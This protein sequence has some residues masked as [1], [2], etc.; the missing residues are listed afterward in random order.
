MRPLHPARVRTRSQGGASLSY[1]EAYDVKAMLIRVFGFGGFSTHIVN[2]DVIDIREVPNRQG[3]A[4]NFKA[5]VMVT[6]QLTIPSL[7][8][9]YTEAAVGTATLPDVGQALDMATKT[10]ESDAL[11]RCATYLGTQFGLG[12]YN[13]GS[14]EEVVRIIVAPGQEFGGT[15]VTDEQRTQLADSI[16]LQPQEESN[17]ANPD[18]A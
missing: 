5:S 14:T 18:P 7:E 11:K 2:T 15:D 6:L 16:G 13:Q 9:S 1:L 10:A 17:D 4:T 12:L 3:N 8:A